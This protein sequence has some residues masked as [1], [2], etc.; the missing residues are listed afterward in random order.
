LIHTDFDGLSIDPPAELLALLFPWIEN[1]QRALTECCKTIGHAAKDSAL[2]SFLN[3]LIQLRCILLQDV[4]VLYSK[5]PN[6]PFLNFAPFNTLQ[7]REFALSSLA[8]IKR[9]EDEARH[10]LETLPETLATSMHGILMTASIQNERNLKGTEDLTQML[11]S[12]LRNLTDSL[13]AH[14]QANLITSTKKK[15]KALKAALTVN[16]G[17]S[18]LFPINLA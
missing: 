11:T 8:I 10:R 17:M 2:S 15:R 7:F 6:L 18:H 3:L 12:G 4:A 14:L 1:E 9:A 5:H 13:G 16:S